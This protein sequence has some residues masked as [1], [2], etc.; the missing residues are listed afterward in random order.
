MRFSNFV[1]LA[2]SN[3]P[4]PAQT[5]SMRAAEEHEH[6]EISVRVRRRTPL[7]PIEA[8]GALP[9]GERVHLSPEAFAAAHGAAAEDLKAVHRYAA[10]QGLTVVR[11]DAV[12]RTVVI[13]GTLGDLIAAF[14]V[15]V[16]EKKR[17][18]CRYRCHFGEVH[19]PAALEGVV[20]AIFG[21]SSHPRARP[22]VV[23]P[24]R[25]QAERLRPPRA[26]TS[27]APNK[28]AELYDFPADLD[29]RGQCIGILEFGGGFHRQDLITYFGR[30]GLPCPEVVSV[31][32]DGKRNAPGEEADGEVVLDIEVAGAVAPGARIA[33]YFSEWTEKGWVDAL[34]AA[35]HDPVNR[36]SVLS[37]SWGWAELEAHGHVAWT[38]AAIDAVNGALHEAALLGITVICAAGDDGVSD[39]VSGDRVHVDFP[40]SSPY[41]LGCGGTTLVTSGNV[42]VDE[43]TWNGG[44]RA[45]GGGGIT[46]GGVSDVNPLPPWQ[47]NAGVPTSLATGK[48]GRGVPDIAGDADGNTGYT[49]FIDGQDVH[50]MGGTSA[51]APLYAGLIARINQALGKPVGYLNPL[52]YATLSTA[53]VFR[54]I[55]A[56]HNGGPRNKHAYHAA[57]GWDPCTGWG[58]IIG[59]R[60]LAALRHLHAEAAGAPP[61]AGD[62]PSSRTSH[63]TLKPP[64]P[65]EQSADAPPSAPVDSARAAAVDSTR[66]A[67][68]ASD[69]LEKTG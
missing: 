59:S 66:A 21:F 35:I 45:D 16:R 36:P 15:N 67:A 51:V 33:V 7:P 61:S 1:P 17:A 54:D 20:E 62:V 13:T 43:T 18:G 50:G 37:I 46:G 63:T 6:I 4:E 47:A 68:P 34:N 48:P 38:K 22:Y 39:D 58:S 8:L 28:I 31:S 5:P 65:A 69:E 27:Y 53:G 2:G 64:Q 44:R 23:L 56:G 24:T 3:R 55:T 32:V 25:D 19:V 26:T 52:L 30:M 14:P 29:G 10:E 9:L 57:P 12:H 49:I 40:A 11:T 41:V 42:I 60:F